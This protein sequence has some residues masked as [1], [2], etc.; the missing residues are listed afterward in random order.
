M[1]IRICLPSLPALLLLSLVASPFVSAVTVLE[2]DVTNPAAVTFTA[3]NGVSATDSTLIRNMDGITVR[4][5]FTS[6]VNYPSSSNNTGNLYDSEQ[7]GGN[8]YTGF[9][10]FEYS[11]NDG[12]FK[13]ANDLSVFANGG[14]SVLDQ[15]FITG[16]VAFTGIAT[17]NFSSTAAALPA[18]GTSGDVITGYFTTGTADHGE[19]I[20][21]WIIVPEPSV[22]GLFLL[23]GITFCFVRRR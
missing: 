19:G 13:P 2:I 20:G 22:F 5:F 15:V 21:Q 9:G 1:K 14:D 8:A 11:D 10:T 18:A 6:V 7:T 17:Y 3:T 12:A 23:G 4:D 16:R